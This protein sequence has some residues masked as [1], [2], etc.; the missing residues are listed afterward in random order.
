MTK[1]ESKYFNTATLMDEALISLLEKKDY[2]YITIK[3]VCVKAGVNRSTFYLHYETMDDLLMECISYC[4][5]T[6]FS[7]FKNDA[8]GFTDDLTKKNKDDLIL[9]TPQ[10]LK[11]YLNLIKEHKNL[12]NAYLYHASLFK[13]DVLYRDVYQYV[14]SPILDEFDVPKDEKK[15]ITEFYIHAIIAV[16]NVWIK[17]DC[18]DSVDLISDFLIKYIIN[19]K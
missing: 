1:S 19:N 9:I 5:N 12:Y 14:I 6:F 15:Y 13:A 17:N 4:Q 8:K 10:Y 7:Y 16:V 2:E 18:K 11:P 3:E